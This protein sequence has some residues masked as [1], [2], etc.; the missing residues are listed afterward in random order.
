VKITVNLAGMLLRSARGLARRAWTTLRALLDEVLCKILADRRRERLRA[1]P[2]ESV[3]GRGLH[4]GVREEDWKQIRA[5][6]YEGRGG[7]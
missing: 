4:S 3:G 1:L 2:D 7:D 6:V 5:L